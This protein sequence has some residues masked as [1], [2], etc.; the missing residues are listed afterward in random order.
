MTAQAAEGTQL[1][2]I[3]PD[4]ALP[5]LGGQLVR[6]ADYRGKHLLIFMWASW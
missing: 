1:G 2:D 3:H 5:D 4:I 6:L